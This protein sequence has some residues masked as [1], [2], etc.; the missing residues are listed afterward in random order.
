[1]TQKLALAPEPTITAE[2]LKLI[3]SLNE[4]NGQWRVF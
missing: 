3:A 1:M 2:M 4:F